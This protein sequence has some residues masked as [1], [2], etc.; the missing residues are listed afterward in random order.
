VREICVSAH[1]A[2]EH[3][4]DDLIRWACQQSKALIGKRTF[5]RLPREARHIGCGGL[6]IVALRE[7]SAL[8]L[9]ERGLGRVVCQHEPSN[10][11]GELDRGPSCV[12]RDDARA[13]YCAWLD[14]RL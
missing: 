2:Y 7:R 3:E 14:R 5:V 1:H 12:R 9:G 10:W 4:P 13:G 8:E 6:F 11:T